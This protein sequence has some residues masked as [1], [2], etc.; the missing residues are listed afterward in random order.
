MKYAPSYQHCVPRDEPDA[1]ERRSAI[2]EAMAVAI[3][4]C[5]SYRDITLS[6]VEQT[7]GRHDFADKFEY[8]ELLPEALEAL[9]A[10]L[11]KSK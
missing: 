5:L 7:E 4:D 8:Y 3:D 6:V 9:A 10:R 1:E 2:I 11:R